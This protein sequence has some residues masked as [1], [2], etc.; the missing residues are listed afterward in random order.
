MAPGPLPST[1]AASLRGVFVQDAATPSASPA[2]AQGGG[3]VTVYSGRNEE[4]IGPVIEMASEQTGVTVELAATLF[5]EGENTPRAST[6]PRM[7]EHSGSWPTRVSSR[8]F[9]RTS[10]LASTSGSDPR[11]DCGSASAVGHVSSSITPIWS[12]RKSSLAR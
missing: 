7:P 11:M 8:S 9:R 4:L 3:S 6:S 10:C 1:L 2:V 5:E 12:A